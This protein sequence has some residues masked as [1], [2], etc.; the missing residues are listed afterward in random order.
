MT[1]RWLVLAAVL[2]LSWS[3][4]QVCEP[5]LR[6]AV[7]P[8]ASD[9]QA[10]AALLARAVQLIEPA[11]PELRAGNGPLAGAGPAA[12]AVTYLHRR[13]LLP[14]GWTPEGH[15]PAAWAA[16]L[17]RFTDGYRAP[18]PEAGAGRDA[19]VAEAARALQSVADA[20][21]PVVVFAVDDQ[22]RLVLFLVV[23]NWTPF[24]RLLVWRPR[25]ELRLEAA[26]GGSGERA[27]PLLAA[28]S[29]CALRFHH[30][31]FA[32]E[33]QALRLFLD[34]GESSFEVLASDPPRDLARMIDPDEVVDLL[35]FR[36]PLLAGVEVLSGGVVGPNPGFGAVLGVLLSART[37]LSLEVALRALAIP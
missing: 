1:A 6:A 11:Y 27:A 25:P 21:R 5:E 12:E 17:A 7:P 23:W 33:E 16:M 10:A 20:V 19:M 34:Q 31:L 35:T 26:A 3:T 9:G 24:P 37:N 13:R 30:F 4:A 29:S 22:E 36:S 14:D 8:G 15:G 2:L 32:R 18:A 28:M